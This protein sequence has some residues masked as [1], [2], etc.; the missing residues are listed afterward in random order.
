MIHRKDDPALR[1]QPADC[2][3]KE[4][5][6]HTPTVDK[7]QVPHAR[8]TRYPILTPA[9]LDGTSFSLHESIQF[10]KP[11]T[12]SR[13]TTE[14][15][16]SHSSLPGNHAFP[17]EANMRLYSFISTL[18]CPE[19]PASLQMQ[20]PEYYLQQ[21]RGSVSG[22][23]PKERSTGG[24]E[25]IGE[26]EDDTG[27]EDD[28]WVTTAFATAGAATSRLRSKHRSRNQARE[29]TRCMYSATGSDP[30]NEGSIK[31]K[32]PAPAAT[33]QLSSVPLLEYE[34][35]TCVILKP[36]AGA[37]SALTALVLE[38]PLMELRCDRVESLA[39]R[40]EGGQG[41]SSAWLSLPNTRFNKREW[42][43]MDSMDMEEAKAS[44][45]RWQ[46]DEAPDDDRDVMEVEKRR[47]KKVRTEALQ[48]WSATATH[49]AAADL[50]D[51]WSLLNRHRDP[52]RNS[53]VAP[54]K[55]P[56][57]VL[58]SKDSNDETSM[59]TPKQ[60]PAAIRFIQ[61]T[62]SLKGLPHSGQKN[63]TTS[64]VTSSTPST[65][66]G[67]GALPQPSKS[68]ASPIPTAAQSQSTLKMSYD[69]H[70]NS[71][72]LD[73]LA[74][75]A[76]HIIT[77]LLGTEGRTVVPL[78]ELEKLILKRLHSYAGAAE[79]AKSSATKAEAV[80]W[81]ARA[82][83]ALRQWLRTE[84]YVLDPGGNVTLSGGK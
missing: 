36:L 6:Q 58:A 9:Q 45:S 71:N 72:E 60:S 35:H 53:F 26:D 61:K 24:I 76:H 22:R 59:P 80:R 8:I 68:S 67:V 15:D 11:P 73:E 48:G 51:R 1:I 34:Q 7:L 75:Q 70:E 81:F 84:N 5:R 3:S 33:L 82:Q 38:R 55:V 54:P 69:S 52:H 2:S 39:A 16:A 46:M 30:S 28:E 20:L 29:P 4:G 23:P 50:E 47:L 66:P 25:G 19:A 17:V 78:K 44:G 49:D 40:G 65:K 14:R 42:K 41:I 21:P 62:W 12:K 83:A 10:S 77:Q 27:I 31:E 64:T 74:E 57:S 56:Q 18:E 32:F 13:E 43:S 37:P 63:Q 79:K